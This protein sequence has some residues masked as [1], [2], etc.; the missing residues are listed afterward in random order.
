MKRRKP[1]D[2]CKP[3]KRLRQ[4]R[5]KKHRRS[6]KLK[7]TLRSRRRPSRRRKKTSAVAEKL[8]KNQGVS[9]LRNV[10]GPKQKRRGL[11]GTLETGAEV[12]T[13]EWMIEGLPMSA[14]ARRI[15]AA[16]RDDQL[17]TDDA[18]TT[19]DVKTETM[20]DETQ[21]AMTEIATGTGETTDVVTTVT[22]VMVKTGTDAAPKTVLVVKVR[23]KLAG[24]QSVGQPRRSLGRKLTSAD[25]RKT[26]RGRRLRSHGDK[27]RKRRAGLQKTRRD[28]M[29]NESGKRRK[30]S[31]VLRKN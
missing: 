15:V 10:V 19:E 12:G 26:K 4:S 23:K 27:L 1:G 16:R 17:T 28:W 9:A 31:N 7:S 22:G 5:S 3:R 2:W 11:V 6:W 20:I 21:G 24:M 13:A 29:P 8:T 14:E 25:R 18:Q 30:T